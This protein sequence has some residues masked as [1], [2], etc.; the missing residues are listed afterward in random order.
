M[1]EDL[2]RTVSSERSD[3]EISG[4]KAADGQPNAIDILRNPKFGILQTKARPPPGDHVED[5]RLQSFAS[6]KPCRQIL[7]HES[8]IDRKRK[9]PTLQYRRIPDCYLPETGTRNHHETKSRANWHLPDFETIQSSMHE[10]QRIL[11]TGIRFA[12]PCDRNREKLLLKYVSPH[13]QNDHNWHK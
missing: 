11:A 3:L 1:R 5:S 12:A 8:S 10:C 4:K 7:I 6:P 13:G 2:D 9:N